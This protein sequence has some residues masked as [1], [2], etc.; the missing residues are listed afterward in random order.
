MANKNVAIQKLKILEKRIAE[1]KSRLPNPNDYGSYDKDE[2]SAA[3]GQVNIA[4][5]K[6]KKK[7][8]LGRNGDKHSGVNIGETIQKLEAQK[9]LLTDLLGQQYIGK[10]V[11]VPDFLIPD[12][13]KVKSNLSEV[14]KTPLLTI[15]GQPIGLSIGGKGKF[16]NPYYVR[17][18][19]PTIAKKDSDL[20]TQIEQ[21]YRRGTDLTGM[22][23]EQIDKEIRYQLPRA[24]PFYLDPTGKTKTLNPILKFNDSGVGTV[25]TKHESYVGKINS[26]QKDNVS[27]FN[28]NNNNRNRNSLGLYR[29]SDNLTNHYGGGGF[30]GRRDNVLTSDGD[31]TSLSI[32]QLNRKF[33]GAAPG[34]SLGVM[35]GGQKRRY[36]DLFIKAG[37]NP[38]WS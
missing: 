22:S 30:Y 14:G 34:E 6:E 23:P 10:N 5:R 21:D 3:V 28:N 25:D 19:N 33:N 20:Y 13:Q 16:Y 18:F 4:F 7:W 37:G 31:L 27:N 15:G 36:K 29:W 24:H 38:T 1:L 12:W 2:Y 11:H 17:Q 8:L 32:N 26:N 35:T 9:K